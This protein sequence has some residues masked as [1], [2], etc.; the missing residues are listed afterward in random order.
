MDSMRGV[1]MSSALA[2]MMAVALLSGCQMQREAP[3]R[4]QIE[5]VGMTALQQA[6]AGA[7]RK[8]MAW[9]AQNLPVAQRELA[10]LYKSRAGER[11]QAM[12]LF[13]R[14]ARGGDVEAAFQLGEMLRVGAVGVAAQPAAAA[15]WYALAAGHHHPRAALVLGQ[16]YK[17][18][19][20]VARDDKLAAH[21]L[22]ASSEAGNPHA[23]FLLSY[24]YNEG[25]GVPQNP[26]K[27]R[28]LLEEAAEH[29][30]PPALQELAMTVQLGDAHSARD[31]RRAG[32]LLKE[33][34]EHRHNNWNRF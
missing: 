28:A 11:R 13:E 29:E 21:W 25:R 12:T 10:L 31:E 32:Y 23:M 33:A 4:A 1:M 18:G 2:A 19:D 20:G 5:T 8:L 14:A 17:N 26:A 6:D 7:E 24:F 27:G 30:Y 16:L 22:E 3:T 15:P 34:T 9:S